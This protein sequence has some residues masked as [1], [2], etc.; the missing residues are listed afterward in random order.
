MNEWRMIQLPRIVYATGKDFENDT[1]SN[2]DLKERLNLFAEEFTI[3]GEK[4]IS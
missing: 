3:F 2:D 4:L 1:I